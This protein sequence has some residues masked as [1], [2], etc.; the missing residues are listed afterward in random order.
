MLKKP[1]PAPAF[2]TIKDYLLREIQA[3]TWKEGAAIPSEAMLAEQFQ[4]SRMTVNRAVRELSSE[5]ILQRIQGSGT[6][7]AQQKY[8]ATLVEIKSIADEIRSRGHRHR[9]ELHELKEKPANEQLALEFQVKAGHAL[10]HSVIVHFENDLAIQVEDRWVNS[11]VTP[12]YLQQDFTRMTPNEYLVAVAPLQG[13][14]YRIEALL[15]PK[16]IAA[17]LHISAKEAC[18]VLHRK[19]RSQGKIASIVTMWHP[20]QHYQFAGSF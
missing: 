12:F 20:G 17:M 4:V 15:P 19:T 1:T 13:V 16:Q 10:Y 6:Y 7:V 18:L 8:Q 9:S 14:D 3:G 11:T 5:Q 2:Q